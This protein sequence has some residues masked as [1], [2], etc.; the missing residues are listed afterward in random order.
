M[1]AALSASEARTLLDYDA[2]TGI[3]TWKWI[4]GASPQ[5]NAQWAGVRAGNLWADPRRAGGDRPSRYWHIEVK[6]R[7]YK[8]H[9]LAWLHYHGEWP[10]GQI[11]HING[12]TLDNRI[13]NLRVASQSENQGNRCAQRSATGLKG[14]SKNGNKFAASIRKD[15]KARYLGL[16][17]TPEEAHAAY[18]KAARE[19]WGEFARLG[20]YG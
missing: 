11:D 3:F 13:A 2:E 10:D 12:D 17:D 5:R 15:G 9:R 8:A 19:Q 7:C 4:E 14:V 16:F 1:I 18:M 20:R 6:R